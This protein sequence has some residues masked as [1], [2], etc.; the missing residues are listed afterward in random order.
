MADE[1]DEKPK[2]E[3]PPVAT[4]T[5]RTGI[6][7]GTVCMEFA[8]AVR[9]VYMS[10]IEALEIANLLIEKAIIIVKNPSKILRPS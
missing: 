3:K 4:N 9:G 1:S 7:N 2:E 6:K 8:Q 10:P 5:V